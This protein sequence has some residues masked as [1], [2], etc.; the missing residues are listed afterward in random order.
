[1]TSR[2]HDLAAF[3]ALN[4]VIISSPFVDLSLSTAFVSL[5]ACFLGGLAPDL[6]KPTSGFWDK[7]PAGSIFGKII[8]PFLGGHRLISH[9]LLGLFLFGWLSQYFLSLI[10][11]T[12]LVNMTIVWNAFMIG[13]LSHLVA[14]SFTHDGVPWLFPIPIHLGFPPFKFLRI[15][16]GGIVEK[17]FIFP[18]L[19][20]T[21]VYL[22]YHFFPF[23]LAFIKS[24][25]K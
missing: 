25:I 1:M 15:K 14:D 22:F 8:H 16:T 7:I 2:T 24:I 13:Y 4:L 18:I 17:G 10:S 6:D 12:L 21:N 3:T 20:L 19:L 9:S 23:Y 11:Q 5:G